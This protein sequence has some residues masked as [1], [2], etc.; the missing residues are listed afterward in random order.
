MV[1]GL[2]A[3]GGVSKA[4]QPVPTVRS[5]RALGLPAPATAVRSL[6]VV[7]VLLGAVLVGW[8]GRWPCA[9]AAVLFAG[10]TAISVRLVRLGPGA[11][12][13]GCFGERSSRPSWWHVGVDAAATV[14]LG[15]GAV[16]ATTGVAS[17]WHELPGQ[18]YVYLGLDRARR[19]PA[20]RADD[21]AARHPFR[22]ARRRRRR[23]PRRRVRCEVRSVT[24]ESDPAREPMLVLVI[25]EGVVLAL[26]AVLVVGLLRSHAEIL[27]RL[28][29]LGAGAYGDDDVQPRAAT[30]MRTQPGVAEPREHGDGRPRRVRHHAG[31]VRRWRSA[32]STAPTPRCW[33][34]SRADASPAATSGPRSP[35]A[36]ARTSRASTPGCVVV[37][38]G[39]EAES[40]SAVEHLAHGPAQTVMS[41]E[42]WRDYEVPVS[43]YFVLADGRTG[44]IVGEGS[45]T[46][47]PQVRD[48]LE[49]ACADAGLVAKGRG[50]P[51]PPRRARPRAPRRR[52][53]AAGRH[54]AG[55]PEPLRPGRRRSRRSRDGVVTTLAAE[56]LSVELPAGWEGEIYV[57]PPDGL[58]RTGSGAG[59]PAGRSRPPGPPAGRLRPAPHP[60][61]LRGWRRGA[62]G[63]AQHLRLAL[64]ARTRVGRDTARSPP[65]VH[66]GRWRPGTSA[67]TDCNVPSR[68]RPA[69]S[70]SSTTK[71][72]RSACTRCWAATPCAALLA[73]PLNHALSRIRI[74]P[75]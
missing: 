61:R 3:A 33:R 8:A 66:L 11:G 5:L 43:P 59:G 57:R 71:V 74:G 58:H 62:D 4:R 40:V 41:S 72:G 15:A 19:L 36:R 60:R 27:R 49:Q 73:R 23:P 9:A 75:P 7:E 69:G 10:F 25:L 51:R 1:G 22:P 65:P 54:H 68:A 34:S 39:P 64:R 21:R 26:L 20:G 29:E 18:G 67:P 32:W 17:H 30:R 28:H 14:V 38:K 52:R 35:T 55:T 42:A 44:R 6:A 37:T 2:L 13:C 46:T 50:R 45:G 70:G 16:T 53:V 47:W 24:T 48:L 63:A 12:S 31:R 56:G